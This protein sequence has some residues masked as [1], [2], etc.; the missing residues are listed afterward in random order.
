MKRHPAYAR[1][2]LAAVLVAAPL[3]ALSA[4]APLSPAE[5]PASRVSLKDANGRFWWRDVYEAQLDGIRKS[6]GSFDF[7]LLGDSITYNW[8]REKGRSYFGGDR[9][10]GKAVA[11]ECFAGYRW[12][13]AG[14]GGD[15]TS[16]VLWRCMNGVLDGYKTKVIALMVGTNN[17]RDSA[18][19][20][21]KGTKRIVDVIREKQPGAKILLSPILP[22]FPREDDPGDMNAKNE[23]TNAIIK[24][25]CDGKSVVWF[26]WR[27]GLYKDGHLDKDLWYD[28]EHPAEGGYRLWAKALSAFL[29]AAGARQEAAQWRLSFRIGTNGKEIVLDSEKCC[30]CAEERTAAGRRLVWRGLD[31]DK[32]DGAVDVVCTIERNNARS[33]DEYRI[34]VTNRSAV[35]GL[36][37][38]E[39]PRFKSL[40]KPGE[41]SLIRPGGCWGGRR[42]RE[43]AP[44]RAPFP[45]WTSPFQLA[46]YEKD[47]GGGTMVAALDPEGRI[48]FLNYAANFG[49][50]FSTPAEGA[51]VPGKAGAPDFAVA[52][53][54]FDGGWVDAAKAYRDWAAKNARWMKKGLL[55]SRKDRSMAF[56]DIGMWFLFIYSHDTPLSRTED[57]LNK[58]VSLVNGRFPIA[59]HIYNWHKHPLDIK[60]PEYFPA[61][62]G[63]AEM[64]ERLGKKGVRIMPYLN[65][66]IWAWD[67]EGFKAVENWMCRNAD[68]SLHN[69]RWTNHDFSAVCPSY[70]D[71][72]DYLVD[73]GKRSV[74]EYGAGALYYDQ[75]A[76]MVAVPCYAANHGHPIGGGTHWVD[77]YRK[78]V[79]KIHAALPD[80]PLT[81]ENWSEPYTDMFDGFLVWGPNVG[82]D[83]PLIPVTYSGYISTFACRVYKDVSDQAFYSVQARS[84]LWGAQTGWEMMPILEDGLRHRLEFLFKL[85]E[86]RRS[87]LEF[88]ADGELLGPVE[89]RVKYEPLKFQVLRWKKKVDAEMPPV[90]AAEWKAPSGR[91]M[92]AVVNATTEPRRFEGAGVS[93]DLAPLE[94]RIVSGN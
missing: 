23:K 89:N 42:V 33:W 78:A 62:E 56:R 71:W 29:P 47:A 58:A 66:R 30:A 20:V 1:R 73:I 59:A 24:E 21:A 46:I 32:G 93:V 39:Y 5:T 41:G 15:G 22:R 9:R 57:E 68:G 38:T 27:A 88:F 43:S 28:R 36:F 12:L 53:Y 82:N 64:A 25:L 11:D 10:L 7:V 16:Q 63:Y 84:F 31:L 61:R 90:M 60:L 18:E 35:Y 94:V 91:R 40:M 49:I 92:V 44:G 77:G 13:N 80:T 67:H 87:A 74:R 6:G 79:E 85:A 83:V 50:S 81:S 70:E 76:S 37:E 8:Q 14:I 52:L 4:D 51:G 19:D 69:E 48:K 2:L 75:I 26:D 72:G 45:D 17:R 55:V 54:R 65:G 3:C 34:A 86:A